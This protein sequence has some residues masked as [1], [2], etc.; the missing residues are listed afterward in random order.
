MDRVPPVG[1]AGAG[2]RLWSAVWSVGDVSPANREVLL[3]ACKQADR[4]AECREI[5]A[6]SGLIAVDRFGVEQPHWAIET[7]RKASAAAASLIKQ[8]AAVTKAEVQEAIE[9]D[10]FG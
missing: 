8:V 4:A 6:K 2:R 1:L 3:L 5:L 7:E 9:E 10:L